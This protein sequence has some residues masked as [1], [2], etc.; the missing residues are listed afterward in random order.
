MKI[1]AK[2]IKYMG[3][4]GILLLLGCESSP[5]NTQFKEGTSDGGGGNIE[6]ATE[7][8]IRDAVISGIALLNSPQF[9]ESFM[10]L[11]EDYK[12]LTELD[13]KAFFEVQ[14]I[15]RDPSQLPGLKKV[16]FHFQRISIMRFL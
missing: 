1:K 16:K 14:R 2:I 6:S 15:L 3:C 4:L 11:G 10:H 8:E 13:Q 5:L 7:T 9:V 12:L